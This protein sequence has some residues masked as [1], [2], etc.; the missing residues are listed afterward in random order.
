VVYL[1][2]ILIYTKTT[3]EHREITRKV[4]R[5]LEENDLYLRPAKCEFEC[6]EVKY[7]G[8]LIQENHV[9]MDPAKLQPVTDWPA[10]KNL[11]DVRRFLG[12]ANFYCRFIKGFAHIARPLN[13]LTKKDVP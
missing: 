5:R 3:K 8:M 9:S 11:K 12:F 13:D 6:T 1:D 10:P 7:L 2:N 4:L